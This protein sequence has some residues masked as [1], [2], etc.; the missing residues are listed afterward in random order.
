MQFHVHQEAIDYQ[1]PW[2]A[3]KMPNPQLYDENSQ[4]A[5]IEISENIGVQSGFQPRWD[6]GPE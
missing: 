1:V 3:G 2:R 6:M 5:K 4:F